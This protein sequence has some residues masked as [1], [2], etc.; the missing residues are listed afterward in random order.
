MKEYQADIKVIGQVQGVGFRYQAREIAQNLGLSG[1]AQN[2]SD[3]TV[4]M[5]VQ[6]DK[7]KIDQLVQWSKEGPQW[8]KVSEVK[9]E[10][11]DPQEKFEDFEIR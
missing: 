5:V 10:F 4:Q 7:E 11:S 1:F 3:G 8:A 9:V 6:G 2:L